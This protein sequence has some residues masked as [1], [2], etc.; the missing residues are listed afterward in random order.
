[1]AAIE[2]GGGP[3]QAELWPDANEGTPSASRGF[4]IFSEREPDHGKRW[5]F[6]ERGDCYRR[7]DDGLEPGRTRRSAAGHLAWTT[8]DCTRAHFLQWSGATVWQ[9][10]LH[11]GGPLSRRALEARERVLGKE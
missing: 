5:R 3:A 6:A 7:C 2:P 8:E 1:K 9:G 11:R 4:A 10:G